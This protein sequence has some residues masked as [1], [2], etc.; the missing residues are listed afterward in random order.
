MKASAVF[1][2]VKPASVP[3]TKSLVEAREIVSHEITPV[4]Y[5]HASCYGPG[6]VLRRQCALGIGGAEV[7]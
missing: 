3:Y 1:A 5:S 6:S 4:T 2:V 7:Q